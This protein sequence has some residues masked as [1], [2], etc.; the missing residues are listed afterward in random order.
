MTVQLQN[1]VKELRARYG[2]TQE[3][4]GAQVG[5]TRQTIAAIERGNYV[6]SLLL[7]L[8]ICEALHLPAEK[9]FQLEK[10]VAEQ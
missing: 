5:V 3:Q 2:L 8:Q 10:G 6:P 1:R 7:G 9:V 4:L